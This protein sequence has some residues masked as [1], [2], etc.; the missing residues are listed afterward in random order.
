MSFFCA[1]YE[2]FPA[3]TLA[4]G[5]HESVR[6]VIVWFEETKKKTSGMVVL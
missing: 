6:T 1:V 5:P 2:H 4:P 3:I